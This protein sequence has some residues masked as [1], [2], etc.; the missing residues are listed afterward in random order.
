MD[1]A[2]FGMT[3]GTAS[4]GHSAPLV[5]NTELPHFPS[6][7][8]SLLTPVPRAATAEASTRKAAELVEHPSVRCLSCDRDKPITRMVEKSFE[9][10]LRGQSVDRAKRDKK[11]G[12]KQFPTSWDGRD[13]E[14]FEL[15][16]GRLLVKKLGELKPNEL[17]FEIVQT[18][19]PPK[20]S[21]RP[22]R[23]GKDSEE[24]EDPE[25]EVIENEPLSETVKPPLTYYFV[26]KECKIIVDN[27]P[28]AKK[29][30]SQ[31]KP[32][33]FEMGHAYT[34]KKW[35]FKYIDGEIWEDH[36][37]SSVWAYLTRMICALLVIICFLCDLADTPLRLTLDQPGDV[38]IFRNPYP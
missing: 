16:G 9:K 22:L 5:L 37:Y 15:D 14:I 36:I 34:K 3:H 26:K 31:R 8:L 17:P 4:V 28:V 33:F 24:V 1:G 19:K 20:A 10:K 30:V 21:D 38:E 7:S 27:K 32:T 25:I 35:L 11:V 18:T 29:V 23:F 12:F 6:F 13:V 2:Q